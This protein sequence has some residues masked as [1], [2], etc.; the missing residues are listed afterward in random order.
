MKAMSQKMMKRH[1]VSFEHAEAFRRYGMR[2]MT[3]EVG[4]NS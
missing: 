1:A 3:E 4:D 2:R